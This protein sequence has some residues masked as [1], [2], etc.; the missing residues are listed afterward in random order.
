MKFTFKPRHNSHEN[1]CWCDA[2]SMLTNKDYDKVYKLFKPFIKED[3]TLSN[4]ILKGYLNTFEDI[5]IFEAET[6]LYEA[7][8]IYNTRN[9]IIISTQDSN[10]M[11]YAKDNIIY[12]NIKSTATV[13]Y[14]IDCDVN[15]VALKI[16]KDFNYL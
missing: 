5:M 9:G 16:D 7:M 15:W 11:V 14:F 3:G 8:Q 2:I 12:D 13:K 10:H 1:D 6:T 4:D